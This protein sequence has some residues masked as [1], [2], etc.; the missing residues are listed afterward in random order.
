MNERVQRFANQAAL[1]ANLNS[2]NDN[3]G[4]YWIN[5]YTDKFVQLLIEDMKSIFDNI[6]SNHVQYEMI[7]S[8]YHSIQINHLDETLIK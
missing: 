8:L 1:F 7:K 2:S 6:S 4:P 5:Q 3:Y